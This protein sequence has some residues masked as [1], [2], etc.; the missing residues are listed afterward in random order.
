[1]LVEWGCDQADELGIMCAL[2]AST[3]GEAVY[4]KHGF[5]VKM[6]IELDLSPFGVDEV[7]LRRGMIREP[8]DRVAF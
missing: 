3:A 6:A 8:Q 2:A 7:E 4:K 5:E 1:M